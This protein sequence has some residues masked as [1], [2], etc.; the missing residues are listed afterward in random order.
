MA[1]RL[2]GEI[3]FEALGKSWTLRYSAN[4]MCELEAALD[5]PIGEIVGMLRA[6]QSESGASIRTLRTVFW[7]GLSDIHDGLTEKD[8]GEII[9][10]IGFDR[11]G[12]LIGEALALA[13]PDS[14]AAGVRP[15]KGGKA[16][17]GKIS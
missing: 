10:E 8:A 15:P 1:N 6:M 12:Q 17:T 3:G 13:F 5:K 2:K 14:S 7:G 16:G 4:A 9:T 11:T